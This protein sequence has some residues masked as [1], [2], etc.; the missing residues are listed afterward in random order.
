[1]TRISKITL[2]ALAGVT[3][4]LASS[5]LHANGAQPRYLRALADLRMARALLQRADGTSSPEEAELRATGEIDEAIAEI[6]GASIDDGKAPNDHQSIDPH[7][8]RRERLQKALDQLDQAEKNCEKANAQNT[9]GLKTQ[10]I[11][12]IE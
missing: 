11:Q 7:L 6:H 3:L 12:Q 1:M 8:S 5:T 4:S 2:F 10:I 9:P